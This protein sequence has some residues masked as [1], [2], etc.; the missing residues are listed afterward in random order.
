MPRVALA[1]KTC[2]QS[3]TFDAPASSGAVK[4]SVQFGSL[5][6]EVS[7]DAATPV[8]PVVV[9]P[10]APA[11]I[12][13]PAPVEPR[14]AYAHVCASRVCWHCADCIAHLDAKRLPVAYNALRRLFKLEGFF[15]SWEC[16][17]AYS[18]AL[19]AEG[20]ARRATAVT[21][22]YT[23]LYDEL[24]PRIAIAPAK[25]DFAAFGGHVEYESAPRDAALNDRA[26]GARLALRRVPV[27]AGDWY[28]VEP[29]H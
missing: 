8:T 1:R 25:S 15:C 14:P 7:S 26:F 11:V 9:E 27:L 16:M 17:R 12:A 10:S 5:C 4:T 20:V 22:L 2:N 21:M 29:A 18:H 19:D 24:P 28:A 6:I 3:V 13:R 23:Q